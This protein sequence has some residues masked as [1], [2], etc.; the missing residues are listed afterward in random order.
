MIGL[1][2]SALVGHGPLPEDAQAAIRS[3]IQRGLASLEATADP[4]GGWLRGTDE[5]LGRPPEI[6]IAVSALVLKGVAQFD[7]DLLEQTSFQKARALI[8]QALRE[9]GAFEG[10]LVTNYV[11]SCVVS[12]LAVIEGP[13]DPRVQDGVAWLKK[14][15]W[16]GVEGH[17]PESNWYGGAGYGKHQRPDLSNTQTMLDALRDAGVPPED[18]AFQRAL[19]FI[20][21]AQNRSESNPASWAGDD[22]GFVYTPAGEGESKVESEAGS[23]RSYGSMTYAGFKSLL[24]AGLD[25][26]D[27]RVQAALDWLR[28][29]WTLEENPGL[30]SQGYFYYLH[31]MSRALRTF[32]QDSITDNSGKIH[33]WRRELAE[34]LL[35]LQEPDGSWV[36]RSSDRWLEGESCLATAYAVLALEEVMAS[37]VTTLP[38]EMVPESKASSEKPD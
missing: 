18:E 27:P 4:R 17:T 7:P 2:C 31:V 19:A 22:G 9:D 12:A 14:A 25:V 5:P 23:L 21:R 16:D 20:T 6:P 10:G 11:T 36:N 30:G 1:L 37:A 33:D 24:Y 29:H 28:R 35:A 34:R 13:K 32:G 15:Q 26:E 8:D 3:S 38:S